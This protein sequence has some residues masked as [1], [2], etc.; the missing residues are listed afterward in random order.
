MDGDNLIFGIDQLLNFI[1]YGEIVLFGGYSFRDMCDRLSI[2]RGDTIS[3]VLRCLLLP[4]VLVTLRDTVHRTVEADIRPFQ[5][6]S[7]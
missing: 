2:D 1:Q 6:P 7:K 5:I 4:G 3:C